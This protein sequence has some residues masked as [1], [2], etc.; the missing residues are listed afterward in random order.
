MSGSVIRRARGTGMPNP[1]PPAGAALVRL[2]LG[3]RLGVAPLLLGLVAVETFA[4]A[5][6]PE[7]P[8]G[9]IVANVV[10]GVC[11]LLTPA[12]VAL[13]HSGWCA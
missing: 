4:A 2:G 12:K 8:F 11:H 6:S 13:D 10:Q 7:E 9:M 1:V 3:V 5:V